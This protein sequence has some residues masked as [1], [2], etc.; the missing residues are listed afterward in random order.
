MILNPRK[1]VQNHAKTL[2]LTRLVMV[3]I[4]G[5]RIKFFGMEKFIV[6]LEALFQA[7]SRIERRI[8]S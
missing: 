5:L 8:E 6:L 2:K 1:I 3:T 4:E 7:L